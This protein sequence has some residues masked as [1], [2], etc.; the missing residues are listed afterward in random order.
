[1]KAVKAKSWNVEFEKENR[2][3]PLKVIPYICIAYPF[4][5]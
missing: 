1:M 3:N 2:Q 5:A 4:C